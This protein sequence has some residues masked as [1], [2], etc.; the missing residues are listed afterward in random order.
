[1]MSVEEARKIWGPNVSEE[2]LREWLEAK[3]HRQRTYKD[4]DPSIPKGVTITLDTDKLRS[5][6]R[7]DAD[8]IRHCRI[9]RPS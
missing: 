4:D 9:C 6:T 5:V 3:N 2:I 7:D 1:M 8:D